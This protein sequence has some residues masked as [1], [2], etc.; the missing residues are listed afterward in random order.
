MRTD[1]AFWFGMGSGFFIGLM[2]ASATIM[3]ILYEDDEPYWPIPV[4]AIQPDTIRFNGDGV[5]FI[6]TRMETVWT[7]DSMLWGGTIYYIR[8][9]DTAAVAITSRQPLAPSDSVWYR[10]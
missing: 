8:D 5:V 7:N 2:V 10:Q 3:G 9:T 4:T 6:P 1:R